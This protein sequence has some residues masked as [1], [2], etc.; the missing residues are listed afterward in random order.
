MSAEPGRK[1]AYSA[2]LR[3]RIVYQ[4]IGMNLTFPEI[5]KNLSIAA[6]T[7]QRV[8]K[9]FE[10]SG[11]VESVSR[12]SRPELR[13]LDEHAELLIIG[14]IL[15]CPTLYLDEVCR[16]VSDL[17]SLTVS[18]SCICRLFKR[19]GFTRKKVRP[20]ALQRCDTLR[21]AFMAQ[22]FLLSRDKFVWVDESGSDAR[23]HIRK[24]GYAIRGITPVSHRLLAR[25]QRV[26]AIAGLSSSGI[27]AF[28]VVKETVSGQTFFDF[29]R[30]QLI[31]Q[32]MPFNGTNPHSIIIMD[33]CS[34]HHIHEVKDLLQQ[35]GI[36]ALY[37]PPY[38]PDLNPIEEAFS[39]VKSYLRKHDNILQS[40]IPLTSVIKVAFDSIS[41]LQCNA[42]ITDSGY[43][44]S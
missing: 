32:M 6:S 13:A 40:G 35:T 22:C 25:G 12:S 1:K 23:D 9:Q 10:D 41:E 29:L 44:L 20:I 24:Y 11:D 14:L 36:L 19:Y 2:D 4:R 16:K 21:G 39:Y 15:E 28:E 43:S 17:T 26:N 38:S 8:Y 34:V 27:V 3:W 33:N 30:G 37:L 7:A 18:P 42:W 31:P 5:A